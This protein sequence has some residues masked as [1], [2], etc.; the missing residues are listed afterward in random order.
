MKQRTDQDFAIIKSTMNIAKEL[1]FQPSADC[2]YVL[3]CCLLHITLQP[4]IVVT[5]LGL[6]PPP[7]PLCFLLIHR[8]KTLEMKRG[9]LFPIQTPPPPL[10]PEKNEPGHFSWLRN[11]ERLNGV[12]L[13][14]S[15]RHSDGCD[16]IPQKTASVDP[17]NLQRWAC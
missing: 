4:C 9:S 11:K 7:L 13:S 15:K 5:G 12:S 10:F 16:P 2:H 3:L 6:F 8:G 14:P 1:R 17:V